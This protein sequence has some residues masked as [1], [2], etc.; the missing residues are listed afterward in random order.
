MHIANGMMLTIGLWSMMFAAGWLPDNTRLAGNTTRLDGAM[1]KLH[2][3]CAPLTTCS[4]IVPA[5]PPVAWI[6]TRRFSA[7]FGS[8]LLSRSLSP[9]PTARRRSASMPL[10]IR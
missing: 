1:P 7:A 3:S 8:P 9:L 2:T 10:S 4:G 5:Q 6:S